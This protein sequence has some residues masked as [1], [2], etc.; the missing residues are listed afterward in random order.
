[1]SVIKGAGFRWIGKLY[2]K[3]YT[4]VM[5]GAFILLIIALLLAGL[6]AIFGEGVGGLPGGITAGGILSF[7]IWGSV[8]WFLLFLFLLFILNAMDC[9]FN[10]VVDLIMKRP[11]NFTNEFEDNFRGFLGGV[12]EGVKKVKDKVV[13]VGKKVVDFVSDLWP[14]GD[15]D[16]DEEENEE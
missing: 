13:E 1:M 9:W 11:P 15:D 12:A 3:I 5:S 6:G 2:M 4:L 10:L 16:D 7:M 14:W 8:V